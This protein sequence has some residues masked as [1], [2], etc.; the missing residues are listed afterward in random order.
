MPVIPVKPTEGGL[1]VW[2]GV[3]WTPEKRASGAIWR[4]GEGRFRN[5]RARFTK[6][7]D[8][9]PDLTELVGGILAEAESGVMWW[10]GDPSRSANLRSPGTL[11]PYE[12]VC[13]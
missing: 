10:L 7:R 6:L 9:R 12:C 4:P 1:A 11:S 2:V 5:D 8:E 13:W 3:A